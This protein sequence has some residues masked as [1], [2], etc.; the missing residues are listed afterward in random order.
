M[1]DRE[2]QFEQLSAYLDGELRAEE[3]LELEAAIQ[4][5]PGLQAELESLR[6]TRELLRQLPQETVPDHF[7]HA[8]MARAEKHHHLGKANPAGMYRSWRW[9]Q[10]ATA[11][12][13]LIAAGL[14]LVVISHM[15]STQDTESIVAVAPPPEPLAPVEG[16]RSAPEPA[17]VPVRA[18]TSTG[19]DALAASPSM[20]DVVMEVIWTDDLAVAR[21]EVAE[22]LADN[23]IAP[24]D[25]DESATLGGSKLVAANSYQTTRTDDRQI[26]LVVNVHLDQVE[27]LRAD[28]TRLRRRQTVAQMAPSG[29]S[30]GYRSNG[31]DGEGASLAAAD[32]PAVTADA[33]P[34]EESPADVEAREREKKRRD[35]IAAATATARETS[36]SG[37]DGAGADDG[38]F[39][40]AMD[41]DEAF[42]DARGAEA[43]RPAAS[44]EAA[45]KVEDVPDF[46]QPGDAA[47]TADEDVESVDNEASEKDKGDLLADGPAAGEKPADTPRPLM[48][49]V[50]IHLNRAPPM[51]MEMRRV[52]PAVRDDETESRN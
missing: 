44:V 42:H 50:V 43:E 21:D 9:I 38:V 46:S 28:L 40:G 36:S 31:V 15:S 2:E 6:R 48:Q 24:A 37:E 27:Q 16:I 12:V 10:L 3:A 26:R 47:A 8:V 19:A 11:A 49:Q 32:A 7:A 20:P 22:V 1:T 39:P 17:A 18:V 23:A 52:S 35:Q 51:D 14:G 4:A 30:L 33:V 13:V 25:W 41:K 34:I 45:A 5:D 29:D